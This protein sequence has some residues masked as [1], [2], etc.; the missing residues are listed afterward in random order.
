MKTL[1]NGK[2]WILTAAAIVILT[3]A[4]S[5]F[6][7]L[8]DIEYYQE[9]YQFDDSKLS[10]WRWQAG[11][12]LG[13]TIV[14]I[15]A[16]ALS[17]TLPKTKL[18]QYQTW[19][20]VCGGLVAVLTG[21]KDVIWAED[22]QTLKRRI[23]VGESILLDM[24][25]RLR[26][27]NPNAPAEER[28][29]RYNQVVNLSAKF[30]SLWMGSGG[31][32]ASP[33]A[34]LSKVDDAF[35]FIVP[36]AEAMQSVTRN[37]RY[38]YFEGV[39]LS[40]DF[41]AAKEYAEANAKAAARHYLAE[42]MPEHV[43]GEDI[44]EFLIE[45]GQPGEGDFRK[46]ADG[47]YRFTA[48]WAIDRKMLGSQIEVYSS[49][50]N[51]RLDPSQMQKT[52]EDISQ[53]PNIT[54]RPPPVSREQ[55]RIPQEEE[56]EV[57]ASKREVHPDTLS[58]ES[59]IAQRMITYEQDLDMAHRM[60]SAENF[61]LYNRAVNLLEQDR[62]DDAWAILNELEESGAAYPI[63]LVRL[64]GIYADA[65]DEAVAQAYRDRAD[66]AIAEQTQNQTQLRKIAEHL[67]AER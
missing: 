32:N 11:L 60:L 31:G 42:M 48:S 65:E 6:A 50:E 22:Y 38:I 41:T 51:V 29:F 14:I 46:G 21:L 59:R 43:S 17:A 36:R 8:E 25:A 47:L 61:E 28:S 30:D 19:I 5:V 63:I 2:S 24:R 16:G 26:C 56:P 58:M 53:S 64:A 12:V 15:L 45:R 37:P 55:M 9:R 35:S 7:Q 20:I 34:F 13:M 44:A 62:S 52:V 67:Q 57:Y 18:Q 27:Y 33:I 39:G 54:R 40:Y 1:R 66:A 3:G 4:S 49:Q 10:A 23:V